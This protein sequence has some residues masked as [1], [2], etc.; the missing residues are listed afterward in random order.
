MGTGAFA[1]VWLA[2]EVTDLGFRKE[3]ALKLLRA[4]DGDKVQALQQEARLVAALRHPNIVDVLAVEEIEGTWT[5]VMEYVDGG[6]LE[7]L[8]E[9]VTRAGLRLPASV[10]LDLGLDITRALERAHTAEGADGDP[11]CILHR[12]LKPANVLIDSAGVAKLTDFGVAKVVGEVAA[13]ATGTAKGTPAYIAPESWA[14]N[15]DF[16]PTVDLFGLGCIL[17]ELV[18]LRRLFDG[19]AITTIFWQMVNRSPAEEVEPVRQ[20]MPGLAPILERLLAREPAER[21][22]A[23]QDVE[24]DLVRLR[25][26][27]GPSGHLGQFLK[28][29]DAA[30]QG[31]E[32]VGNRP[33]PNVPQTGDIAWRELVAR[34][35]GEVMAPPPIGSDE[36]SEL[37]NTDLLARP[38]S[39]PAEVASEVAET[40]LLSRPPA[41]TRETDAPSRQKAPASDGTADKTGTVRRRT[42][43]RSKGQESARAV[44]R[45]RP[46]GDGKRPRAP[47][48]HKEETSGGS[49]SVPRG[50]L[51]LVWSVT[52]VVALALVGLLVWRWSSPADTPETPVAGD[53]T[54]VVSTDEPLADLVPAST[55]PT[56][57]TR[58]TPARQPRPTSTERPTPRPANPTP[59]QA[60]TPE[61]VATPGPSEETP[62]AAEPATRSEP[63]PAEVTPQASPTPRTASG[64]PPTKACLVTTSN[65][66]KAGVWIDGAPQSRRA[67]GN[68]SQLGARMSPGWATVGMGS[69]ERPTAWLDVELVLGR[70]A[71]V[72]CDLGTNACTSSTGDFGPCDR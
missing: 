19:E 10:V 63:T 23:A 5:V 29:L 3:V 55:P 11:V 33:T 7:S 32:N 46:T 39:A 42:T 12:D 67:L 53:G 49:F 70:S 62:L 36:A 9:R 60:P 54:A 21:Y 16:A 4:T 68:G 13:T 22:Q 41:P 71:T 31:G 48:D 38:G 40:D 64:S 1:E 66:A 44:R 58:A 27:V 30:D 25:D 47:V 17:F 57:A 59:T 2:V 20:E 6:T 65:P 14:G 50:L 37:A 61:A 24:D 52:G 28:L 51:V 69:G 56:S 26:L 15:R 18:T 72:H 35:T 8:V 45:R 34:A 43:R